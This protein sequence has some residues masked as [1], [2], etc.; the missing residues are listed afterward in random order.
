MYVR[1]SD[2]NIEYKRDLNGF[3]RGIIMSDADP[4]RLYRCRI[5]VPEIH[6]LVYDTTEGRD[7]VRYYIAPDQIGSLPPADHKRLLE[8]LPWAE[9]ASSLFGEQS[10]SHYNAFKET[11]TPGTNYDTGS[12]R[13]NTPNAQ[14]M[15]TYPS[16]VLANSDVVK[17]SSGSDTNPFNP[18]GQAGVYMPVPNAPHAHGIHGIPSVGAHVWVFFDRGDINCPVYFAACPSG[19]ETNQVYIDGDSSYPDGFSSQYGEENSLFQGPPEPKRAFQGDSSFNREDLP[20][21]L[22]PLYQ[23]YVQYGE[24]Y[25][26]DPRF[27]ASISILETNGGR[28]RAFREGNNAM[29]ISNKRGVNYYR[30]DPAARGRSIRTMARSLARSDGYYR[31]ANTISEV[32]PIYAPSGALN[33]VKGTNS[34]WSR[35]VSNIMRRDFGVE[36]P[37]SLIVIDRS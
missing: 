21:G 35:N 30:N 17:G 32:G 7:E 16:Q 8:T 36:R 11:Q 20:P 28:S 29:G 33:D 9:Q 19:T 6:E 13:T 24:E 14:E 3:F 22:Q 26:V 23:D 15:N 34:G 2:K 18:T 37:E 31:N 27:L 5:F 25:G 4:M 12:R 10:M 1:G